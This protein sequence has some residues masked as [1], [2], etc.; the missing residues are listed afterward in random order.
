MPMSSIFTLQANGADPPVQNG[1]D[2]STIAQGVGELNFEEEEED[3]I[4]MKDL[5]KYAC[6]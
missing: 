1:V 6:A 5:P 3:Q 2:L 4:Y